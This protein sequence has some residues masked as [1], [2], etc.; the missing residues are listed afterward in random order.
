MLTTRCSYPTTHTGS[1]GN[2]L[3]ITLDNFAASRSM[4]A[5]EAG[6]RASRCI[7]VQVGEQP[8]NPRRKAYTHPSSEPFPP[9]LIITSTVYI[10]IYL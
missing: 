6:I 3:T 2:A 1:G 4:E 9:E 5:G 10:Y 7:F 8:S